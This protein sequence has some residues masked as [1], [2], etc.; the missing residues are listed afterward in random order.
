M[1]V[2]VYKRT[3]TGDPDA[4]GCFGV[5][6]CMG[7]VRGYHFDA[8]IGVGGIGHEPQ[9]HG[10]AGK[11]NW[12]GIGP[13]KVSV[14]GK[15]GPEVTFDHFRDFGADGPD[16]RELAPALAERMYANNARYL[17]HGFSEQELAEAVKITRLAVTAPPSWTRYRGETSLRS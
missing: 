4:K 14:G 9:A 11:V 6:D 15:S 16:F 12:I 17:L 5:Y 2:L 13:H 8:V 7:R 10:I 3:H 1:R